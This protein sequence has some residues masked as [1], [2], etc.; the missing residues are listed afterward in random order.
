MISDSSAA[1]LPATGSSWRRPIARQNKNKTK[2]PPIKKNKNPQ[3]PGLRGR[4]RSAPRTLRVPLSWND[5]SRRK[6]L[7]MIIPT[8]IKLSMENIFQ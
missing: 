1:T 7:V 4:L 6:I 5:A 8:M 3:S 2:Q